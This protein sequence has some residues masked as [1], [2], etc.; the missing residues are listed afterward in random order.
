VVRPFP[1]NFTY[2][3]SVTWTIDGSGANYRQFDDITVILKPDVR[4]PS[5][6]TV[7]ESSGSARRPSSA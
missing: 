4:I 7:T 5:A 3:A 6:L 1:S 2:L